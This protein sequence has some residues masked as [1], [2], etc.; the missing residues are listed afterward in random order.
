MYAK[1]V[2]PKKKVREPT[3]KNTHCKKEDRGT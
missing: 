3:K 1:T 2:F